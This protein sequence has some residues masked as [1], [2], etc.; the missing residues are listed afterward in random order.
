MTETR[1][2]SLPCWNTALYHLTQSKVNR[3]SDPE[4]KNMLSPV[5]LLAGENAF[6]SQVLKIDSV[7]SQSSVRDEGGAHGDSARQQR[8]HQQ[9]SKRSMVR[10]GNQMQPSI[11][12]H[13][14]RD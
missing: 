13:K 8:K 2:R 9:G 3:E 7:F 4:P 1:L 12:G 11:V 14:D 10:P 5:C 6:M